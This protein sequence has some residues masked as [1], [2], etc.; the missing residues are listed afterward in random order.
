M[1]R[2]SLDKL[3]PMLQRGFPT[4]VLSWA[5]PKNMSMKPDRPKSKDMLCWIARKLSVSMEGP[6]HGL[7]M[8]R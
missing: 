6:Q 5:C 8:S 1:T 7:I 3:E 2:L 4:A